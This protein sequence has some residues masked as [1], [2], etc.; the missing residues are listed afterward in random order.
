MKNSLFAHTH[1]THGAVVA[2]VELY[3]VGFFFLSV[4]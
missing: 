3:R 4:V 2:P 1:S